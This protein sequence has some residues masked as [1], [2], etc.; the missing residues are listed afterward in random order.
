MARSEQVTNSRSQ[1]RNET[2]ICAIIL[3]PNVLW[4]SHINAH[5]QRCAHINTLTLAKARTKTVTQ[6]FRMLAKKNSLTHTNTASKTP[7][8][9]QALKSYIF[10]LPSKLCLVNREQVGERA[11]VR[12]R[13]NRM[14][15][16][17]T[18]LWHSIG[19]VR[20][21]LNAQLLLHSTSF[22][23]WLCFCCTDAAF[24]V[25][26]SFLSLQPSDYRSLFFCRL[27]YSR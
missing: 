4:M 27:I 8:S 19:R 25:L 17:K 24:V 3:K 18:R 14:I 5:T 10:M 16:P 6:F 23:S 11:K 15:A 9:F 13:N 22:R 7:K 26:S 2:E 12:V 1:H 21:L 20:V